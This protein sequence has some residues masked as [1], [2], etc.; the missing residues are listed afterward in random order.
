VTDV[1]NAY[2]AGFTLT[3]SDGANYT[4]FGNT[5]TP[6][7]GFLG[8]LTVPVQVTDGALPSNTFNLVVTVNTSSSSIAPEPGGGYRISFVG[9][10]GVT[11][12]IQYTD[13]LVHC[14]QPRR[15]VRHFR[16]RLPRNH[17]RHARPGEWNPPHHQPGQSLHQRR[18]R[19]RG[20]RLRRGHWPHREI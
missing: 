8:V 17:H 6:T 4:R 20:D 14:R 3:V 12:T 9:N 15:F 7:A 2:P 16:Q 18:V 19:A 1:D 5:I 11:Y 13:N 10:P